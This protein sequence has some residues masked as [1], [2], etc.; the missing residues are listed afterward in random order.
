MEYDE[1]LGDQAA[2]YRQLA[3][4]AGGS[5]III[6]LLDIYSFSI[7]RPFARRSPAKSRTGSPAVDV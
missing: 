7:W 4:K 1:Y 6:Q 5:F 3:E 2:K